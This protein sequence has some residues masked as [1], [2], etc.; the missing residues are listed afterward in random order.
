MQVS[1]YKKALSD[2]IKPVSGFTTGASGITP[3]LKK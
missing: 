2:K 3:D 1:T